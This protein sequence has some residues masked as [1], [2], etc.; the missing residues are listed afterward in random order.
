MGFT[1]PHTEEASLH[2]LKRVSLQVGEE[3]EQPIFRRRQGTIL[4]HTKPACDPR[5]PV[6]APLAHMRVERR[7]KRRDKELKLVGRQA[8]Q[9]QELRR[10]GLHIHAS[11][12][13]HTWCLLSVEAQHT[14]NHK[15]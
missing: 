13:G 4:V 15:P 8:G 3:E 6:E 2:H 5:F 10:T 14:I 9:I 1:L 11:Y 12:T 7:L